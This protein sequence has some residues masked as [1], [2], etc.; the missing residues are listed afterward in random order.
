MSQLA[1]QLNVLSGGF[2]ADARRLGPRPSFLFTAAQAPFN[3]P[4]MQARVAQIATMADDVCPL[5]NLLITES[6]QVRNRRD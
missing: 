6:Y 1:A 2:K 5:R 3:W 4:A